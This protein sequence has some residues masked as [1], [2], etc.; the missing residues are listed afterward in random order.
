MRVCRTIWAVVLYYVQ[1]LVLYL[2]FLSGSI[3]LSQLQNL[4]QQ[5]YVVKVS[6]D[7]LFPSREIGWADGAGIV[8]SVCYY[9]HNFK[10]F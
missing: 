6:A 10:F 9:G 1:Q 8:E 2:F 7:V 5:L 3:I 4:L